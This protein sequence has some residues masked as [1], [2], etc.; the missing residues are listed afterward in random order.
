MTTASDF[1]R[2]NCILGKRRI[3]YAKLQREYRCAECASRLVM[4]HSE[5]CRSY[6][7]EWHV[8]CVGCGSHSFVHERQIQRQESE[9]LE[10]IDGLPPALAALIK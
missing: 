8:E 2:G 1:T 5:P 9:A 3:S 7:Q 6:P 4:K 10:I